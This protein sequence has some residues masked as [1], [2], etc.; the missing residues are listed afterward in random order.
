MDGTNATYNG[1]KYMLGITEHE[2]WWIAPRRF[3]ISEHISEKDNSKE[4]FGQFIT[5]LWFNKFYKKNSGINLHIFCV[6][7]RIRSDQLQNALNNNQVIYEDMWSVYLDKDKINENL[8]NIKVNESR[9]IQIKRKNSQ[10][11]FKLFKSVGEDN[12]EGFNVTIP[13]FKIKM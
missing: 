12:I 7:K 3:M 4:L 8:K 10:I 6:K 9:E 1:N 13:E 2:K 5:S 11:F